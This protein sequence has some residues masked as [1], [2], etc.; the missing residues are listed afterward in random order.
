M[1]SSYKDRIL[2]FD[3]TVK[4]HAILSQLIKIIIIII[5]KYI[6]ERIE[7]RKKCNLNNQIIIFEK[8]IF[9][10][11]KSDG[12]RA[13]PKMQVFSP[14]AE[15]VAR[16][17]QQSRRRSRDERRRRHAVIGMRSARGGDLGPSRRRHNF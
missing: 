2:L 1:P 11:S 16:A 4:E 14:S 12:F 5:K 9:K 8:G 7:K 13:Q 17:P 15:R 6:I 10:E 3:P